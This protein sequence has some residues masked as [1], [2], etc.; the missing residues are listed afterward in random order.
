V[1]AGAEAAPPTLRRARWGLLAVGSVAAVAA[2]VA[3]GDAARSAQQ[4][5]PP[6]VLVTGLLLLG[7]VAWSD[8][9]FQAGGEAVA[10]FSPN[11][12]ALLVA[13][14]ALVALCTAVLNLDTSVAFLTP[15]LIFA[16][17]RRQMPVAPLLYLS[18][19][20]ANAGSLLLPGSNL[21]NLIVLGSHPVPG[22]TFVLHMAAPWAAAVVATTAAVAFLGR[23]QLRAAAKAVGNPRRPRLGVG[24]L[25][26]LVAVVAMLT[27]SPAPMAGVVVAA[28]VAAFAVSVG[29]RRLVWSNAWAALNPPVLLGLFGLAVGLGALG[30]AWS[31]P[32]DLLRHAGSF[33]TASVGAL[34]SV[35]VNNLPAASLLAARAPTQPYALLIGLNLGP[36]LLVTGALSG[37]LWLQVGRLAGE[38]PSPRRF[39]ALGA[40]VVPVSMAA[41][42]G[43]LTLTH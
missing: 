2:V 21:T 1:R 40:V 11:G 26:V 39:S 20:L 35:V 12:P 25:G 13:S 31:G 15:V 36:N 9:V 33:E 3:T 18:V 24:L 41:A 27:L 22:G 6:F 16:A 30:S 19:F 34:G 42:L 38:R 43:A 29:A 14:A 23:R 37:V 5:W 4:D 7:Q 8:E 17:R 10:R 28:G 32:S